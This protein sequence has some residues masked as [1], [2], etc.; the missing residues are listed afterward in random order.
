[1]AGYDLASAILDGKQLA[2]LDDQTLAFTVTGTTVKID[3][4]AKQLS[5]QQISLQTMVWS[6]SLMQS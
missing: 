5:Q 1:M 6:M 2:T 4:K 3:S